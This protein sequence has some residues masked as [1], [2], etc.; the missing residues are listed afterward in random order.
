MNEQRIEVQNTKEK[1]QKTKLEWN[2]IWAKLEEL[3]DFIEFWI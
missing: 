1:L 3:D 2:A